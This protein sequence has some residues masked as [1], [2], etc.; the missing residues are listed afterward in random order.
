MGILD[1]IKKAFINDKEQEPINVTGNNAS[2]RS[3]QERSSEVYLASL[4][5]Q[6]ME[7]DHFFKHGPYSPI[8]DRTNFSGL[9]YYPPDPVYRYVLPLQ[10]ADQPELLTFQTST[11]DEQTYNRLGTIEFEVAGE[12]ARLAVYKSTDHDGLFLPFRDA[13]SGQETYGA[14]RYLEPHELGD[15]QLLVDFN[16]A[17]NP[18][19]AYSVHYSCPL[20][21]FENH[22]TRVAIRAGEKSFK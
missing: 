17:Y 7:K 1:N 19:C 6:R 10:K 20:P 21:P 13:T 8:E 15:G 22:L 11:G 2:S 4:E 9:D 3:E 14:G 5:S 12:T 18:F 16:L